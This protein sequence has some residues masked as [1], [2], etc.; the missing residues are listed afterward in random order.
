[1]SKR[2]YSLTFIALLVVV[3]AGCG[4]GGQSALPGGNATTMLMW[5]APSTNT[6]GSPA[7][8]L[9][10][11]KI[12]YGTAPGTYTASIDV[13]NTTSI[14][15]AT[16]SSS[17]PSPGLYYISVTAYDTSGNESIYSNTISQSL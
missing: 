12:Y 6:D 14:P 13:G 1:L 7:T 4:G 8:D 10:G 5:D 16:L 17:V 9:A 2:I 3:C 15:V 11:Y